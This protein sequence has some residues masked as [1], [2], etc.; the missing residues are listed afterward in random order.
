ME[1]VEAAEAKMGATK[2][3]L[4]DYVESRETLDADE[5]RRLVAQSEKSRG[6]VHESN[7]GIR[8]VGAIASFDSG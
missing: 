6:G 1:Q 4:L 3:A 8:T 7:F 5:Y 2:D